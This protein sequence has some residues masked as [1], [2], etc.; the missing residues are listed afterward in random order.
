MKIITLLLNMYTDFDK[1][2][3]SGVTIVLFHI[4]PRNNKK[5]TPIE[6][7]VFMVVNKGVDKGDDI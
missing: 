3:Y 6:A 7:G 1:L 4:N 2:T 5:P